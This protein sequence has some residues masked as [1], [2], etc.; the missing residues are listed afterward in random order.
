[1]QA[2]VPHEVLARVLS[3]D[4]VGA[5]VWVPAGLLAGG[6]LAASYGIVAT[7][8]TAASGLFANGLILLALPGV[9][10]PG[11]ALES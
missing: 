4:S 1:M 9:R 10:S 6:L 5:I 2:I 8:G 3:I 11:S 7:Y